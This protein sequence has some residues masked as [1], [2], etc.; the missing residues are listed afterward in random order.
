MRI[1]VTAVAVV[2]PAVLAPAV[3][4]AVA[5]AAL[6]PVAAAQDTVPQAPT[7]TLTG[8]IVDALNER[9]IIS[10]VIKV[11]GLRRFAFSNV[12]G[13]FSFQDFPEGTWDIVVE[14]LGYHTLDGSVTVAEG[15]GLLLRLNP[16]PIA[17]E[18][19]RVRTR[20]DGLLERRRQRYPYRV[21]TISSK[22]IGDSEDPDP[23]A[24]FRRNANSHLMSCIDR[25]GF[26]T[27]GACYFRRGNKSEVTVYL[28][29]G[30]LPGGISELSMF[31]AADVHSMDWLRDTGE[32]HVYTKWFMERLNTSSTTL[33]SFKWPA[34]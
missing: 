26:L 10:A 12:S 16:D 32:L 33:R 8:Q 25:S 30:V 28:D 15:N 18:G 6:A 31:P 13:R 4:A 24:I 1:A 22:T 19:L 27:L 23:T 5:V 14:M 21:T 17:L 34:W 20:A 29:D 9:P 3:L 7:F 2:A 11:P